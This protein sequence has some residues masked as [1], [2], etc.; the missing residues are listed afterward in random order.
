LNELSYLL[1][2]WYRDG[3]LILPAY[4]PQNDRK[5]VWLESRDL[6]SKLWDPNITGKTANVNYRYI[7]NNK[8]ANI[9]CKI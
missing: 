1:Q 9:K 2:I 8:T 3:G 5:W 4:E 6:I 7:N